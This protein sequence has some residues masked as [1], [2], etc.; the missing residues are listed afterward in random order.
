MM[1]GWGNGNWCWGAWEARCCS[2]GRQ[3]GWLHVLVPAKDRVGE[4]RIDSVR[5]LAMA[6][7]RMSCAPTGELKRCSSPRR[8]SRRTT[9]E[10]M[11][12]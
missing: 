1:W 8:R 12:A 11:K 2:P 10:T 9:R 6:V 7:S 4:C 3:E 5:G